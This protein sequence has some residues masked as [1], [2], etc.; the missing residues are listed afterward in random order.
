[1]AIKKIDPKATWKV[2]SQYDEAV[3]SETAEEK[4]ALK[5]GEVDE[6]GKDVLKSTRYQQYMDDLDQSKLVL[7]PNVEP[8]LFV[9]RCIK[10]SE[11]AE[12]NEKYLTIDTV[13]KTANH[14]NSLAMFLEIFNLCCLGIE[15]GGK[16][17]K[18]SADEI[19]YGPA[20]EIGSV[21]YHF[22]TLGKHL[23]K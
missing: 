18:T 15:E 7:Q 22:T 1:M 17:V 8:S 14:K 13:K 5:T 20:V 10:N 12:L 9:I 23:K 2:I 11:M 3:I 4:E 21:I 6:D 16:I 19:G